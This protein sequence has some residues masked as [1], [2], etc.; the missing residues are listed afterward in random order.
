MTDRAH[1]VALAA[2]LAGCT[3]GAPRQAVPP[4]NVAPSRAETVSFRLSAHLAWPY[5]PI[6][7]LLIVD[8]VVRLDQS[9]SANPASGDLARVSFELDPSDHHSFQLLARTGVLLTPAGPECRVE[10]RDSKLLHTVAGV[11]A[12]IDAYLTLRGSDLRF[13]ERPDVRLRV[14][15][16]RLEDYWRAAPSP[17]DGVQCP[18]DPPRATALCFVE[19]LMAEARRARDTVKVGCL[20]KHL[21]ELRATRDDVT[22]RANIIGEAEECVGE[23][24]YWAVGPVIWDVD[25]A[26]FAHGAPELESTSRSR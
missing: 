23:L 8:H 19:A 21:S 14:R 5:R 15:G 6:R 20:E 3:H 12:T 22:T 11:P 7:V 18:N 2:L 24:P 17:T 26:C 4:A 13:E 10:L 1:F 16:A 9:F 25:E